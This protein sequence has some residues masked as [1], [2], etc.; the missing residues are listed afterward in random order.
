MVAIGIVYYQTLPET[1]AADAG[2]EKLPT[3]SHKTNTLT[4]ALFKKGKV[5]G[6][7]TTRI[8]YDVALSGAEPAEG[9]LDFI[10]EDRLH[11]V[12]Y[13]NGDP[14]M[15]RKRD[16]IE[17]DISEKLQLLFDNDEAGHKIRNIK[18]TKTNFL[19]K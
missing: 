2:A 14:G 18:L 12:V 3:Q 9:L 4:I 6:H 15:K 16:E 8:T 17:K 11:K 13:D 19:I 5:I 7:L 1:A 10:I